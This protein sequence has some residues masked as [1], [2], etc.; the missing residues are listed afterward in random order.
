MAITPAELAEV[1]HVE[2]DYWDELSGGSRLAVDAAAILGAG[3]APFGV[4]GNESLKWR[5]RRGTIDG[6]VSQMAQE[7]GDHPDA[8]ADRMRWICQLATELAVSPQ[9]AAAAGR[10]SSRARN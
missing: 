6:C 7:F 10:A 3:V 5:R 8:D 1:R 9:I 4:P 2:Y